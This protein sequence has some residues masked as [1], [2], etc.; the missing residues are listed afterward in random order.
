M[1]QKRNKPGPKPE[2]G[3]PRKKM[4]G[5]A[6]A[7]SFQTNETLKLW[8]DMFGVSYG[9]IVDAMVAFAATNPAFKLKLPRKKGPATKL[10]AQEHEAP[11]APDMPGK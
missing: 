6:P 8:H 2:G 7:V 1:T 10:Y 3:K 9:R 11:Q 4:V 5:G